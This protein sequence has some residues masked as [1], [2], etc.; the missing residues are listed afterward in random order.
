M[1]RDL[2]K[3]LVKGY[4][5]L[6]E[7]KL[8]ELVGELL[9]TFHGEL[10]AEKE[11]TQAEIAKI[12]AKDK[13]LAEANKTIKSL[14]KNRKDPEEVQ[15]QIDEYEETIA[16]L[17]QDIQNQAIDNYITTQ[18][19][20]AG[21]HNVKVCQLALEFDKSKIKGKEDYSII[22]EAIKK[23]QKEE[24]YLYKSQSDSQ[25]KTKTESK[26]PSYNP[27]NGKGRLDV[28][29]STGKEYAKMLSQE[30][31]SFSIKGVN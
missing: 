1:K 13:E 10:D 27:R 21:A 16:T 19:T 24:S 30:N 6:E 4:T 18:L 14:M 8:N 26:Q 17:R 9:D 25:E 28:E 23:Q 5:D 2:L 12:E 3:K 20:L 29:D 31:K 11:L 22:D 7:D 15:K